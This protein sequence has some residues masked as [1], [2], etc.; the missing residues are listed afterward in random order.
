MIVTTAASH[1]PVLRPMRVVLV[2]FGVLTLLAVAA[3]FVRPESTDRFFAWTVNPPITAAFYGAAYLAGFALV[4]LSLRADAWVQA[5][6]GVVTI[7]VF[8]VLSLVATLA[9]RDRFHFASSPPVARAAAWFWLAVYLVVP[10][11]LALLLVLQAR[12][13]GTHPERAQ[14][15]PRSL[16]AALAVEGTVLLAVGV[17]LFARPGLLAAWPWAL[18]PLTSRVVGAWL[19]SF[20]IAAW[21]A[22]YERDLARVRVPAIA[23]LVFGLAELVA[24]LRY[25]STISWQKA[26]SW[27]YLSF[28]VLVVLTAAAGV[29]LTRGSSLRASVSG[30]SLPRG[31]HPSRSPR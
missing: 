17:V 30:G 20:G 14:R 21:L 9:H 11:V 22:V 31:S 15:L 7:L 10:V 27:L 6:A 28:L 12:T 3:L 24:L 8:T 16:A 4:V 1:V 5:R 23:Y 29:L 2:A 26:G 13:P 19:V 18:T 25:A